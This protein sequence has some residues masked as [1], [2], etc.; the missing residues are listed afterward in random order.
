M[1]Q[2]SELTKTYSDLRR[3]QFVAVD[4]ISFHAMQGEIFGLLGP[5]GAG[6][7]TCFYMMVGLV[8]TNEGASHLRRQLNNMSSNVLADLLLI[9]SFL[10]Q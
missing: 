1:I 5:N 3:G 2:V 8:K 9:E 4:R 10:S 7:T 6:K